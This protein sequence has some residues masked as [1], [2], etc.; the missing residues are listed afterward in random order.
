LFTQSIAYSNDRGRT[1]TKYEGNP[2]QEHIIGG[3][4]DPKVIWFDKAQE[5]VIILE[6]DETFGIFTSKDLKQWQMQSILEDGAFHDC[7]ELFELPVD[8]DKNN[9]MWVIHD[10]TAKYFCGSAGVQRHPQ[11]RW[12]MHSNG[13][14]IDGIRTNTGYAIQPADNISCRAYITH[15]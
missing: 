1:F 11:K 7:P 4:R 14:G 3:N 8:G 5:W 6:L 10:G 9:T 13:M 12:A 15:Y 2:V